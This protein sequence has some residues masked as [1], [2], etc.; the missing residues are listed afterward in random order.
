M[1]MIEWTPKNA[2]FMNLSLP[3][4][5]LL[6]GAIGFYIFNLLKLSGLGTNISAVFLTL[7]FLAI[8]GGIHFDG[9]MDAADGYFSRKDMATRLIIMSDSGVG[10]FAVITAIFQLLLRFGIFSQILIKPDFNALIFI[11]IPILSRIFVAFMKCCFPKAKKESLSDLYNSK[12]ALNLWVLSL[13]FLLTCFLLC[14]FVNIQSILIVSGLALFCSFF[15]FSTKKHFGGIT[16]DLL[17]AFSE[18]SESFM[19]LIAIFL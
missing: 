19:W 18:L 12:S 4:V 16:G 8:T 17:G 9:L 5:G 6:I 1:P 3:V 7:F 10:A 15:Y 2:R 13:I 11:F 14:Y